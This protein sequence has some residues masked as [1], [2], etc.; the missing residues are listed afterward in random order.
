MRKNKNCGE[1]DHSVNN[2]DKVTIF[3]KYK[4]LIKLFRRAFIFSLFLIQTIFNKLK[5]ISF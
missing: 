5:V 2:Y 3:L 4:E 1:T